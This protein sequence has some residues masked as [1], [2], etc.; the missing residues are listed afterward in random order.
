M[1]PMLDNG[2]YPST[3]WHEIDVQLAVA[4]AWNYY[5]LGARGYDLLTLT[6]ATDTEF[7]SSA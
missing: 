3:V 2:K 7:P 4:A 6:D 5:G 1:G